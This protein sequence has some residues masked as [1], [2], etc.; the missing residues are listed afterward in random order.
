M[1]EY[2]Q[3]LD[4]VTLEHPLTYVN[5][6]GEE[7]TYPLWRMIMHLLNHQSYHRGQITTLL[8]MLG[9]QRPRVDF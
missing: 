9:V 1:R 7:W 5:T 6:R 3:S 2:L 8:R 4:E